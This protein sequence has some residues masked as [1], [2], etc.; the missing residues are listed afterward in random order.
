MRQGRLSGYQ[1]VTTGLHGFLLDKGTFETVDV[2]GAYFTNPWG[3]N[4]AGQI[5]GLYNDGTFGHGFLLDKGTFTTIDVPGARY[6]QLLGISPHGQ[7]FGDYIDS[8]S[9]N[10]HGFVL[11]GDTFTTI[12]VPGAR[13]T[14]VTGI[15]T[16]SNLRSLYRRRRSADPW[17]CAEGRR[18][19][20][21]QCP[22][23]A[24]YPTAGYQSGRPHRGPILDG[25]TIHGF[26]AD[27]HLAAGHDDCRC[28]PGPKKRSVAPERTQSDKSR[29]ENSRNI[30]STHWPVKWL[31]TTDRL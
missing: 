30:R 19:H 15:A 21:N 24:I 31:C 26:V 8:S 22:W 18:V 23:R 17:I 5:V 2:P 6:T 3:I 20:A 7:I 27:N 25:V 11:D 9:V 12:D 4:S 16:W 14:V 29:T 28:T 1:S 13:V 10:N